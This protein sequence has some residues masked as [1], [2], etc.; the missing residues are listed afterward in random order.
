MLILHL[1]FQ[2]KVKEQ[3]KKQGKTEHY[4]LPRLYKV[5]TSIN[6][7]KQKVIICLH[8]FASE[9]ISIIWSPLSIVSNVC[10]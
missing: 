2:N 4:P 8:L 5:L 10:I 6:L 3:N 9:I 7:Y 1:K